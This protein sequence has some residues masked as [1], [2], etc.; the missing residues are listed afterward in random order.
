MTGE[1]ETAV[2][3]F[4]GK[5]VVVAGRARRLR[6]SLAFELGPRGVR[7]N[8]VNPSLILIE[9]TR[10]MQ[11]DETPMAKFAERIPL[12]RGASRRRLR[13]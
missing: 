12:S 4:S 7:V 8:A 6:R 5:V 1:A 9:A 13:T 11:H 3:R 2:M 10:S